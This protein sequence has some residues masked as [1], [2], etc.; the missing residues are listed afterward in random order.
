MEADSV[1]IIAFDI[2]YELHKSLIIKSTFISNTFSGRYKETDEL[3][4]NFDI[5]LKPAFDYIYNKLLNDKY[6]QNIDT[7][8][9]INIIFIA[10]YLG[11]NNILNNCK[12]TIVNGNISIEDLIKYH[13]IYWYITEINDAAAMLII[14]KNNK[15]EDLPGWVQQVFDKYETK[16][17]LKDVST[18]VLIRLSKIDKQS[19][20]SISEIT[21]VGYGR[22]CQRPQVLN[23]E[24]ILYA[25]RLGKQISEYNINNNIYYLICPDNYPF[26]GVKRPRRSSPEE[27]EQDKLYPCCF[28]RIQNLTN[29]PIKLVDFE[30][31]QNKKVMK[32]NNF[33]VY[34]SCKF[35][36]NY[37]YA[38]GINKLENL[39]A[40]VI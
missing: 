37:V 27:S 23:I 13:D 11:I 35:N 20:I 30:I 3:N 38:T 14:S 26:I 10:D 12:Q 9:F 31:L 1:N 6:D 36:G 34:V 2:T 15:Y 19:T 32:G 29:S 7:E 8:T 24:S 25:V 5:S 33:V 39:N 40:I 4:L 28:Q 17:Q 18:S 21:P 16:E 22:V